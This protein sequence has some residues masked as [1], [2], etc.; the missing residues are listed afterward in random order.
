M[1]GLV[2]FGFF[3]LWHI[4]LHGLFN[5]N[6]ILVEQLWYYL[7]HNWENKGIHIFPQRY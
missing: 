2:W 1:I 6:A 4:N 5:T 7:T 3:V